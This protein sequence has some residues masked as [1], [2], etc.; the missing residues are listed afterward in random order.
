MYLH[1]FTTTSTTI[2]GECKCYS[3]NNT[4]LLLRTQEQ[5]AV[6]IA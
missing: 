6:Y 1:T 2:A 4:P 5:H 3:E